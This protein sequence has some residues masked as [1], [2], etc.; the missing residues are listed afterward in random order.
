MDGSTVSVERTIPAPPATIF[1]LLAD[2][3]NHPVLDGSGTVKRSRAGGGQ[4]LQLGSVFE[5]TMKMGLPYQTRN[6][7]VEYEEDR[8][9]AWR[10]TVGLPGGL[11]VGGRVWR[12]EL[13]PSG[14]GTRVRATWDVS[15][16]PLRP[17]IGRVYFPGKT[18]QDLTRS[19]ER[20]ERQVSSAAA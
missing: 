5:M 3:A 6:T 15:E 7:V 19:M 17:I 14:A 13:E 9:I 1:A 8:V 11:E 2:A 16:D 18:E 12:W 4:P 10:T 20:I